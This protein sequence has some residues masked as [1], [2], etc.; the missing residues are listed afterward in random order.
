MCP[1]FPC[2][3]PDNRAA[4]GCAAGKVC[5]SLLG[6]WAGPS[7]EPSK[8]TLMQVPPVAASC[9][10]CAHALHALEVR[11][12]DAGPGAGAR[13]HPRHDLRQEPLLQW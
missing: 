6:T 3:E 4:S 1:S 5:L 13:V 2:W 12:A 11:V 10:R 8:S 7:W 9:H